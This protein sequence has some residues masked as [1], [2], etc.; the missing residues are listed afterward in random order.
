M[1]WTWH[2]I[3][4]NRLDTKVPESD[5]WYKNILSK[6]FSSVTCTAHGLQGFIPGIYQRHLHR[7]FFVYIPATFHS[8]W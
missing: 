2:Q 8:R 1:V 6:S 7:S 3:F 5:L 4:E